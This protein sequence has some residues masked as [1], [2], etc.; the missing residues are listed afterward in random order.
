MRLQCLNKVLAQAEPIHT[1]DQVEVEAII[2][3]LHHSD[4]RQLEQLHKAAVLLDLRHLTVLLLS[5]EA[6]EE[7]QEVAAQEVVVHDK[8]TTHE[9][10]HHSY[11]FNRFSINN[12]CPKSVGCTSL[13]QSKL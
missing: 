5:T 7:D 11:S 3:L 1:V 12:S 4:L 9:K 2:N 13:F 8:K 6:Q 10:V